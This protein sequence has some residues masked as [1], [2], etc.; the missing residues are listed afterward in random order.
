MRALILDEQARNSHFVEVEDLNGYLDKLGSRAEILSDTREGR[1][2][3]FVAFYANDLQTR[4]A[5]ITL[6]LVVPE[7]RG[8][9]LGSAL[10]KGALAICRARGFGSCELEVRQDNVAALATYQSLGFTLAGHHDGKSR[11]EIRL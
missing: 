10:V 1:C 8:A 7:A 9:G 3:G 6:V 4:R 11:L 5:F 2:L